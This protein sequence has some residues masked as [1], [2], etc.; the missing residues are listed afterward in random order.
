MMWE[1]KLERI[2]LTQMKMASA[3]H[4]LNELGIAGWELVQMVSTS[5]GPTGFVAVLKRF[6]DR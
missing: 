5:E 1:Y 2:D 4:L 3:G 6:K